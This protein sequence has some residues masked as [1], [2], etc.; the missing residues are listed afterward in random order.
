MKLTGVHMFNIVVVVIAKQEAGSIGF[1]LRRDC[2][3][4]PYDGIV[5]ADLPEFSKD[6]LEE[7][8]IKLDRGDTSFDDDGISN[9]RCGRQRERDE[10][11]GQEESGKGLHYRSSRE[12]DNNHPGMV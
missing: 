1:G 6:G 3:R 10:G 11:E 2:G 9:R 8:D 12:Y 4:V 5:E 7:S